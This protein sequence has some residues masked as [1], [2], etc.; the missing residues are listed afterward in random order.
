MVAKSSSE[1]AMREAQTYRQ[2]SRAAPLGDCRAITFRSM[3]AMPGAC[4]LLTWLGH[5]NG[6]YA[7]KAFFPLQKKSV[8]IVSKHSV[9]LLLFDKFD[10]AK[11][12][13]YDDTCHDKKSCNNRMDSWFVQWDC[14]WG[15]I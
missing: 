9:C 10:P 3:L 1:Y 14:I 13:T 8:A 11:I 5:L 7:D 15:P 2:P 4:G 12:L 6:G